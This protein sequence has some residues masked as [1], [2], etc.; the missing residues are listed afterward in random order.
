[1]GGFC[2]LVL[3]GQLLGIRSNSRSQTGKRCTRLRGLFT[4]EQKSSIDRYAICKTAILAPWTSTALDRL[5]TPEI[6]SPRPSSRA[7]P[8]A[9]GLR[10]NRLPMPAAARVSLAVRHTRKDA[11]SRPSVRTQAVAY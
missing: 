10:S 3:T 7:R 4:D 11:S 1:M 6:W 9:I 8:R 5:R 2:V